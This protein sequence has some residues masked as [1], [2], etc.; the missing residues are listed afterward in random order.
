MRQFFTKWV[1]I[2][3]IH[4]LRTA[5]ATELMQKADKPGMME[6]LKSYMDR[7]MA[8]EKQFF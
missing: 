2:S 7:T 1:Y 5:K 3:K 6:E 4:G 8:V